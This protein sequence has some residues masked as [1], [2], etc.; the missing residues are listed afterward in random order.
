MAV[1]VTIS[2]PLVSVFSKLTTESR[3]KS[4]VSFLQVAQFVA[5][6]CT[7]LAIICPALSQFVI[8]LVYGSDYRQSAVVVDLMAWRLLFNFTYFICVAYLLG[9][10]SGRFLYVASMLSFGANVLGNAVLT[11]YYCVNGAAL[12]GIISDLVQLI[13]AL[14]ILQ[15]QFAIL[16]TG[17]WLLAYG[18]GSG[19]AQ[20]LFFLPRSF[21]ATFL[22]VPSLA[23]FM[24]IMWWFGQI[25]KNPIA[26]LKSSS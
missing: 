1:V 17:R 9:V 13:Y 22:V 21:D 19:S 4:A 24:I 18:L 16:P 10:T 3:S 7:M 11:R 26:V 8:D 5:V 14:M 2:M 20:M 15:R 25:P 6:C 23:L 12:A